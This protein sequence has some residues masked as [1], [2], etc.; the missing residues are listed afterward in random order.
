MLKK[1]YRLTRKEFNKVFRARGSMVYLEIFSVKYAPPQSSASRFAVVCG[2]KVSKKAVERN[3]IRRQCYES[4]RRNYDSIP[5]G[6]YL[7]LTKPVILLRNFPQI[8]QLL[9]SGF[10]KAYEIFTR[11]TH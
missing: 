9:L 5:E 4:I 7:V 2:L 11:N 6:D 10:K 1:Q 3:R 8:D